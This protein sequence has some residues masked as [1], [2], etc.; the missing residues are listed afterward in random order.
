VIKA[1]AAFRQLPGTARRLIAINMVNSAGTGLV[2]PLLVVFLHSIR[3]FSLGTATGAVAATSVGALVGSPIAG[4]ASDR[5]GRV[6]A[7]C[8]ALGCAALGSIGYALCT[9]PEAALASGLVQGVGLAGGGAWNALMAEKVE[10]EH[11]PVLFSIDFATINA[12]VGIGGVAG[13]LIAG[14]THSPLV[15]QVLYLADGLSF[16]VTALLVH[17]QLR[18]G[19]S[20][21][22]GPDATTVRDGGYAGVVRDRRLLVLLLVILV[23]F[24]LGYSQLCSGM[25][26]ALLATSRFGPAQLGVLYAMDTATVVAMQFGPLARIRTLAPRTGL[27][28]LAASWGTSWLLIL[29]VT[30]LGDDV[31]GI[32]VAMAAMAAFAVGESLLAATGPAMVNSWA[33]DANRGRYNAAYGFVSSVGFAIGPVLSGRLTQDGHVAGM[34]IA[35]ALV[36]LALTLLISRMRPLSP[37]S[38]P[39]VSDITATG[40]RADAPVSS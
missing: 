26:A 38:A 15:F 36:L 11:W 30:G 4:W 18:K 27:A 1:V 8:A 25:P 14:L 21:S 29:A 17:L 34:A 28:L 10:Q 40:D 12:V 24:T 39:A 2:L 20:T 3:G 5:I 37:G 13:G 22:A 31:P 32:L 16:L 7:V 6:P 33:S 19:G 23:L 9:T 35:F